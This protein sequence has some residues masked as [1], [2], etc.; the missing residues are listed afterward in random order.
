MLLYAVSLLVVAQPSSEV[1]EGLMNYPV[2][3]DIYIYMCVCVCVYIYIHIY[4]IYTY[5]P[6][7]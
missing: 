5:I 6:I 3:I 4:N 1:P 2:Y 7:N